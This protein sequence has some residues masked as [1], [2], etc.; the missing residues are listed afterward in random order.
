MRAALALVQAAVV[1]AVL[2]S[3]AACRTARR[4]TLLLP[5]TGG[6]TGL[7]GV[8]PPPESPVF[9]TRPRLVYRFRFASR[10]RSP[11]FFLPVLPPLCFLGGMG[12]VTGESSVLHFRDG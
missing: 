9:S 2:I 4:A 6:E 3:T 12:G 8:L 1:V 10:F 5:P 7:P 11:L